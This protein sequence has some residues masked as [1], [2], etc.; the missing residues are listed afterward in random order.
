MGLR[1]SAV[2][3]LVLASGSPRRKQLLSLL[4]IP[5]AIQA[6]HVD[7]EPHV[8]EP[9]QEMVVRVARDKALAVARA[10]PG[11]LIIAADTTVALDGLPVGKPLDMADASR[12]LRLLRGRPHVVFTGIVIWHPAA[13]RTGSELGRSDVWMRE[14]TDEEL[15]EYVAS[16]DPLD[17]AGAYAIQHPVF[18]PVAR[19]DGCWLNVMGMPLCHLGRAL[20]AAGVAVPAHVPGSCRAFTQRECAVGAAILDG[21][22]GSDD[23]W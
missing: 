17:K 16:G 21:R 15:D 8:G 22:P 3:R 1:G 13:Q 12:M 18:D 14:Y 6:A 4:G 7:E 5:F 23:A 10:H 9:P 19:V 2:R 11:E 20:A